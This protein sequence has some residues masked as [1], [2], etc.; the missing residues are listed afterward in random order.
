MDYVIGLI[1]KALNKKAKKKYLPRHPADVAATWAEIGKAQ[2]LLSWKPKVDIE[3]G[4][5]RTV[6]WFRKN[7]NWVKDIELN[8]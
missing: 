5:K 6:E 7:W 1:E 8:N 4:I 3:E 2:E